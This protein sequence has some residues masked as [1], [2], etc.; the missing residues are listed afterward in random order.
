MHETIY[1]PC[2]IFS[3]QGR[4]SSN[5]FVLLCRTEGQ[6]RRTM[7]TGPVTVCAF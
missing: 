6:R 1:L 7:R 4:C 5:S 3:E 2:L